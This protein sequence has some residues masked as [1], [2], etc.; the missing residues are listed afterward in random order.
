MRWIVACSDNRETGYRRQGVSGNRLDNDFT[1]FIPGRRPQGC[2]RFLYGGQEAQVVYEITVTEEY[3]R[4]NDFSGTIT[5]ESGIAAK[6]GDLGLMDSMEGTSDPRHW[7]SC[8][9]G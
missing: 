2:R 9:K 7:C 8:S 4:I 1:F 5:F 6:M 3:A